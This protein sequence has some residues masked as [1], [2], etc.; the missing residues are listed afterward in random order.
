MEGL[1]EMLSLLIIF[2][3]ALAILDLAASRFGADSRDGD[4][5]FNHD[6]TFEVGRR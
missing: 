1:V 4:D 3:V 2:G 6:A 5:W